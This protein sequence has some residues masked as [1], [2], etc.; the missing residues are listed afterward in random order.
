M[1]FPIIE[2]SGANFHMFCDRDFFETLHPASGQ[3]ILGDGKT[4]LPIQG[5]GTIK[6]R[7]GDNT[8]IV[9]NVRYIP[10]LSESIYSLF[11]LIR[12]PQH[13]LNSSFEDG[14]Y[15]T[16]PTF[17]TKAIIGKDDIYLDGA[18]V[19][20][21]TAISNSSTSFTTALA[22]DTKSDNDLFCCHNTSLDH[23]IIVPS[24]KED[25]ILHKL[26]QYYGVVKTKRQL[27]MDVAAGFSKANN[28]QRQM[29]AY[30]LGDISNSDFL[31]LPFDSSSQS[32]IPELLSS[33]SLELV[34][35]ASDSLSNAS[36]LVQVPIL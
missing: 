27:N 31:D 19:S 23:K 35:N 15:I 21:N 6:V 9:D 28:H 10:E 36:S 33:T 1:K 22:L 14:L 25:K 7:I 12:T 34:S 18:P 13:G 11:L 4:T 30:F 17:Q 32:T 29:S 16:F 5:I 8:L 20:S 3:V 26:R 24:R 2:D